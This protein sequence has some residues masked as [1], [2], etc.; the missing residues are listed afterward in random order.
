[1][2]SPINFP[3]SDDV[4]MQDQTNGEQ[5]MPG[6]PTPQTLFLPGTPS[7][8]AGTPARQSGLTTPGIMARRALGMSTPRST[9]RTPLF[10]GKTHR[11]T[12]FV[13]C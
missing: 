9:K 7:T 6:A 8:N 4:E 10:Q 11:K 5:S 3:D 13:C 2:S 12:T 1:M